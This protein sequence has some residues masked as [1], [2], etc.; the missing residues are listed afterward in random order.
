M[1]TLMQYEKYYS[2]QKGTRRLKMVSEKLQYVTNRGS[3]IQGTVDTSGDTLS[4]RDQCHSRYVL[5]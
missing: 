4:S 3:L 1:K 5:V 2:S